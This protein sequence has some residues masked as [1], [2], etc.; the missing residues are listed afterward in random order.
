[1]QRRYGEDGAQRDGALNK[2][3]V[4]SITAV[5]VSEDAPPTSSGLKRALFHKSST[6]R[7][8]LLFLNNCRYKY[9]PIIST[10]AASC[11]T[12]PG[13]DP[14]ATQETGWYLKA[15]SSDSKGAIRRLNREAHSLLPVSC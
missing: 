15:V 7:L 9:Q 2:A 13:G 5:C 4:S 11:R 1:M 10:P 3:G 6:K 8:L 14:T 12:A